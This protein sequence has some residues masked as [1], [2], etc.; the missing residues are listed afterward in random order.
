M[1]PTDTTAFD[2]LPAL[3]AASR[4]RPAE[5]EA[6]DWQGLDRLSRALLSI[7]GTV[8]RFLEAYHDEPMDVTCLEQAR[9]EATDA[10]RWLGLAAGTTVIRR[11][12]CLRGGRTARARA[13]AE[14]HIAAE[15][16]PAR[17]QAAIAESP[18][19]LGQ[20]LIEARIESRREGLWCG[21]QRRETLPF[22]LPGLTGARVLART[23]RLYLGGAPLM[24]IT[25]WFP[26]NDAAE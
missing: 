8:T 23:Y 2:P 11:R 18:T 12:V 1:K 7:D 22:A 20:A 16:L 6:T 9:V 15:R 5:L 26:C 4:D 19:G 14:S 21:W 3:F 24:L 17:L 10:D 25:E 13:W